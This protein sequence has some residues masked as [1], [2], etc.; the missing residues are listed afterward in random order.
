MSVKELEAEIVR[1]A[2]K[3][4]AYL[5]GRLLHVLEINEGPLTNEELDRRADD[6]RTGRVQGIPAEEMM[7]SSRRLL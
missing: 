4:Q 5:F 1:L 2:P 3:D 7:S 6:L